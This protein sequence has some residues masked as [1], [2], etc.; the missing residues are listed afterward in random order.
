MQ[1][2]WAVVYQSPEFELV[3]ERVM[4]HDQARMRSPTILTAMDG[5]RTLARQKL[6]WQQRGW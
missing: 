5:W 6:L 3:P 4:G 2:K 1:S